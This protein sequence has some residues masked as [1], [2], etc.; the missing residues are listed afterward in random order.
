MLSKVVVNLLKLSLIC[1]NAVLSGSANKLIR[2]SV[3][4]RVSASASSDICCAARRWAFA[5]STSRVF[6]AQSLPSI[7]NG[8]VSESIKT[9]RHRAA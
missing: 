2:R 6:D 5:E 8:Q 7:V 3:C 9:M 4:L 1:S